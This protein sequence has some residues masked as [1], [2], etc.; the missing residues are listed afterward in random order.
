GMTIY[1]DFN[2]T[3]PTDPLVGAGDGRI[4]FEDV[5]ALTV[6]LGSGNDTF[7]VGGDSLRPQLPE[8]R[9]AKVIYFDQSPDVMASV[10]GGNGDDTFPII[11]TGQIDR[12]QLDSSGALIAVNTLREGVASTTQEK[13]HIDI[14]DGKTDTTNTFTLTFNGH[15]TGS[16][17]FNAT[18]TQIQTALNGLPGV[19]GVTVNGGSGV[20]DVTFPASM[21]NVDQLVATFAGKLVSASTTTQGVTGVTDEVQ[22]VH[23]SDIT[24]GNG[25]FTVSYQFMETQAMPLNVGLS[26]FQD[27]VRAAFTF[28]GDTSTT[29]HVSAHFGGGGY[30]IDF[31]NILG[32]VDQVVPKVIPLLLDGGNGTDRFRVSSIYEDTFFYGGADSDSA[33]VNLNAI[34]LAPFIPSDVVG[35]VTI[36]PQASVGGDTVE[37]VDVTD[38]TGGTFRLAFKGE[39]T[40]PIAWDAPGSG[41]ETTTSKCIE[42][43]NS[44]TPFCSV[45]QALENLST[46][47]D[48][49]VEVTKSDVDGSY[50]IKFV[51]ALGGTP[52]PLLTSDVV[53]NPTAQVGNGSHDAI[54]NVDI[55]PDAT[56]TFSIDFTYDVRPLGLATDPNASGSLSAGTYYYVVTA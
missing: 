48:Q 29:I 35:H 21:G 4:E 9:Q 50:M 36:T 15:T 53:I 27:A 25:Y 26:A 43:K 1:A 52:Q 42:V 22:F 32:N 17:G 55:A 23:I 31:A 10:I 30:D 3:T 8:A 44:T 38:A 45:Q 20:F 14:R 18:K 37:R 5:E 49:N 6:L 34:T 33:N 28:A 56:G 39:F 7:M 47:G 54:Q 2:H 16:L 24:D 19:S 12:S 41:S 11:S 51:K 40:T 13:Q 46:I